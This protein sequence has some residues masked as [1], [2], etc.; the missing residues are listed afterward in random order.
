M[1][2]SALK[3]QKTNSGLGNL[4]INDWENRGKIGANILYL[5]SRYLQGSNWG[6]T[7]LEEQNQCNKSSFCSLTGPQDLNNQRWSSKNQWHYSG[8]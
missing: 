5:I 7:G 6:P 8:N 1:Q 4:Y 2:I 3:S